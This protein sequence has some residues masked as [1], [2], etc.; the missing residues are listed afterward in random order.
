MDWDRFDLFFGPMKVGVVFLC[1]A[2]F[3]NLWG[4]I[5]VDS[6]VSDPAT[7]EAMRL[8]RFIALNR[9]STR[10]ME[11]MDEAGPSPGQEAVDAELAEIGGNFD[12]SEDWCLVN[13]LGHRLPILCPVFRDDDEIVWRWN[14]GAE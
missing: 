4:N 8:A 12:D 5:V 9:E 11:L 7:A 1:D 6:A 3:P 10:L 2:D 13:V 14:S